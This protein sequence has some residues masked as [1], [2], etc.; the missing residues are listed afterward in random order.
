MMAFFLTMPIS[1][2]TPM[3]AITDRS[4][5]NSISVPSAPIAAEGRPERITSGWVK[6]S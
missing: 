5:R 1:I 6:L 2:S 3:I 4:V